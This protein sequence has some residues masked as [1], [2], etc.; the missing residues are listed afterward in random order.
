MRQRA[1]VPLIA[2]VFLLLPCPARAG[3][4]GRSTDRTTYLLRSSVLGSAG[5]GGASSGF[6]TRGTLGQPTPVGVGTSPNYALFAGFWSKISVTVDVLE[7][8]LPDPFRNALFPSRPNPFN[9]ITTIFFEVGERAVVS[10]A[11]YDVRGRLI[12]ELVHETMSPGRR[13]AVW[14]G[15]D[16]RGDPVGSGVYLC[17]L[18]IGNFHD[19]RKMVLVK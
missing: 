18:R 5:G 15:R 17:R 7:G 1:L 6:T 12:R 13:E 10:I 19:V 2:S 16:A 9:P 14:N 4:E 11:I 8:V 3:E